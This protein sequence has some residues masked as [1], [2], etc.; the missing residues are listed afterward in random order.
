MMDQLI[1]DAGKWRMGNVGILKKGIV[2]HVAPPADRVPYLMT[3]LFDFLSSEEHP[4]IKSSV[5]HYEFEFIHPFS[6]GNGRM[7]R[8][9]HSLLLYEFHPVFE[10]IPVESLI[11]TNQQEYYDVLERCDHAGNSTGFI[12]FSLQ[13]IEKSLEEFVSLFRP[14]KDLPES[15]IEHAKKTFRKGWFTRKDYMSQYKTISS[16]TASRDL[17]LGVEGGILLK[18]GERVT[19]QYQFI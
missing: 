18:K 7:G 12:V 19:T 8:F 17:R 10:Y 15:R 11:K 3:E 9:W 1:P 6:D 16:A 2:A 4:L 14:V 5:F 13:M